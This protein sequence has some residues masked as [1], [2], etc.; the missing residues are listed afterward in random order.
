MRL[1]SNVLWANWNQLLCCED[2]ERKGGKIILVG[3]SFKAYD[4]RTM[5]SQI[6]QDPTNGIFPLL[7]FVQEES[8]L[9]TASSSRRNRVEDMNLNVLD[10]DCLEMAFQD[11]SIMYFQRDSTTST[12]EWPSRPDE[13]NSTKSSLEGYE[14]EIL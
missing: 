9:T 8:I 10:E 14:D 12:L 13:Y 11:C 3:N 7:D 1:Y 2:E 5:D 4:D 6:R